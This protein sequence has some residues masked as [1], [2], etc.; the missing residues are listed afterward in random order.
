MPVLP[1]LVVCCVSPARAGAGVQAA[2]NQAES[3][4]GGA[5]DSVKGLATEAA[6]TAHAAG[7]SVGRFGKHQ[8]V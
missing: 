7:E 6:D 3:K 8:S 1:C 4:L 2:A 5:I